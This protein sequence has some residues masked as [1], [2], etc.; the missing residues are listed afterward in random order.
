M[1]VRCS[2]IAFNATGKTMGCLDNGFS[3]DFTAAESGLDA[4]IDWNKDFIGKEAAEKKTERAKQKLVTLTIESEEI[5]VSNDEAI[6]KNGDQ[7][8]CLFRRVA[9]Y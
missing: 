7:W 8:I 3:S 9:H 4:F 6:L 5:D 1:L 2:S